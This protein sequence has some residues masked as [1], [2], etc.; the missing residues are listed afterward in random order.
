MHISRTKPK[1]ENQSYKH[2]LIGSGRWPAEGRHA[3][4]GAVGR[5]SAARIVG[6]RIPNVDGIAGRRRRR[7]SG[8]HAAAVRRH[9][10]VPHHAARRRAVRKARTARAGHWARHRPADRRSSATRSPHRTTEANVHHPVRRRAGETV[11]R[12]ARA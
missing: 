10:R 12:I 7:R 3:T 8:H 9:V 4:S 6:K 1:S 11:L 5:V 2:T